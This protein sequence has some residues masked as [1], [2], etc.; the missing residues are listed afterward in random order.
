MATGARGVSEGLPVSTTVGSSSGV[1]GGPTRCVP[2]SIPAAGAALAWVRGTLHI[3]GGCMVLRS[4][5]AK[6]HWLMQSC[7]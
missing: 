2:P 6:N 1:G 5:G 4:P 3:A 7:C